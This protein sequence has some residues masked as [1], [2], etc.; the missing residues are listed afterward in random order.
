MKSQSRRETCA[1]L[2]PVPLGPIS[3]A[4]ELDHVSLLLPP[5]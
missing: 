2:V 4:V 3:F 1:F 5:S